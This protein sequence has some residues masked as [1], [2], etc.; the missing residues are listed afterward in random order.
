[1]LFSTSKS[2]LRFFSKNLIKFVSYLLIVCFYLNTSTVYALELNAEAS[3]NTQETEL[4]ISQCQ[5]LEKEDIYPKLKSIVSGSIQEGKE[6]DIDKL[7]KEQWNK[8]K[9]DETIDQAVSQATKKLQ[10]EKTWL[11]KLTSNF[12]KSQAQELIEEVFKL[13]FE[14]NQALKKSFAQLSE[15]IADS[16]SKKLEKQIYYST[17]QGVECLVKYLGNKYP[18]S[19]VAQVTEETNKVQDIKQDRIKNLEVTENLVSSEKFAIGGVALIITTQVVRKFG[20]QITR[21]IL[22]GIA[23][24]IAGRFAFLLAPGVGEIVGGSLIISDTAWTLIEA[25]RNGPLPEIAKQLKAPETKNSIK[26]ETKGIIKDILK[27]ETVEAI[28]TQIASDIYQ[29]WQDFAR[30][31]QKLLSLISNS[32]PSTLVNKIDDLV[33]DYSLDEIVSLVDKSS[34]NMSQREIIEAIENGTLEKGLSIPSPYWEILTLNDDKKKYNLIYLT[35][36]ADVAGKDLGKVINLELYKLIDPKSITPSLLHELLSLQDNTIICK[37]ANLDIASLKILFNTIPKNDLALISSQN[38]RS[39]LTRLA[40][41]LNQSTQE[42]KNKI[43]AL[44]LDNPQNSINKKFI[45]QDLVNSADIKKLFK[46]W[47]KVYSINLLSF[48]PDISQKYLSIVGQYLNKFSQD[49]DNKLI[50]LLLNDKQVINEKFVLN[51]LAKSADMKKSLDF[52]QTIY[53]S[54]LINFNSDFNIDYLSKISS[55]ANQISNAQQKKLINL[56]LDNNRKIS[57]NFI[58]NDLT[59]NSENINDSIYLWQK[60]F[61][62]ELITFSQ[63]FQYEYLIDVENYISRLTNDDKKIFIKFLS[64]YSS[65]LKDKDTLNSIVNSSNVQKA[66]NYWK[67]NNTFWGKVFI[68]IKEIITGEIPLRLIAD[69]YGISIYKLLIVSVLALLVLLTIIYF[70]LIIFNPINL[71]KLGLSKINSKKNK[72]GK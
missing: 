71:I 47:E 16:F 49:E 61:K 17:E 39:Y 59:T 24:R 34:Y 65:L 43:I 37:L 14:E 28:S 7:V 42:E 11:K 56:L 48:T 67:N 22:G 25:S 27:P 35:D 40:N 36:Y 69:N 6:L 1:M 68:P 44:L 33:R 23:E 66:I 5:N 30:K 9:I 53:D 51:D 50:S 54:K 3:S 10:E 21:R 57:I 63:D 15:D 58:L 29:Q 72:E 38:D 8:L 45:L 70:L 62:S 20:K 52:W 12:N 19:I 2:F 64:D 60:L 18:Q 41:Y 31:Y 26:D 13:A 46:F 55:L 32:A 4:L